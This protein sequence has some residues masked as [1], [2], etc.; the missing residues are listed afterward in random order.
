MRPVQHVSSNDVIGAPPTWDQSISTCRAIPVTRKVV[1]GMVVVSTFWEL[2]DEDRA[3][4][5]RGCL[6]EIMVVGHSVQP[7]QLNCALP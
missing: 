2:T 1:D 7:M 3:A 4:L 5:A 6:I